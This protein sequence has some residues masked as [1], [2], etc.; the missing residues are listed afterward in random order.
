MKCR[1]PF[2]LQM[3]VYSW[4][5]FRPQFVCK[6][7]HFAHAF[8]S[9]LPVSLGMLVAYCWSRFVVGGLVLLL[10]HSG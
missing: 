1:H 10:F 3:P 4:T 9:W 7:D 5:N 8:A 6:I 2:E